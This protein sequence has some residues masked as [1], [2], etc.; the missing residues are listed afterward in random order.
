MDYKDI[1]SLFS[2]YDLKKGF[3]NNLVEDDIKVFDTKTVCKIK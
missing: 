2:I 3:N 1:G